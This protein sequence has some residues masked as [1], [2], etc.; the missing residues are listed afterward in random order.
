[1]LAWK[2]CLPAFLVP[3][4]FCLSPDGGGLLLMSKSW[5][6]TAWTFGTS[7]LAVAALAVSF[8]GWMIKSASTL[9]R[10]LAGIAGLALLA[11]DTRLDAFGLTLMLITAVLHVLRTR[12]MS[13]P[14]PA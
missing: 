14:A 2:Y 4:M 5:V 13:T 10:I 3:F 8:G 12:R 6:T 1:M 7:V 11:A 9:E